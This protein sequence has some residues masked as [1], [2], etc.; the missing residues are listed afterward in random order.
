MSLDSKFATPVVITGG[1]AAP[2]QPAGSVAPV[3]GGALDGSAN[4]QACQCN[5]NLTLLPS[6]A[7]TAQANGTDQSNINARGVYLFLNVTAASGTGGLTV[8]VDA[9]DPVSGLYRQIFAA[10]AAVLA[11]TGSTPKV[12]LIYP[13]ASGSGNDGVLAQPLPATWR[14]RVNVGDASSYTYSVGASVLM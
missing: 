6:A 3:L 12:Y 7:R 11:V 5:Q 10:A 13:G 14:V 4:L 9:K 2:G 8:C 1:A